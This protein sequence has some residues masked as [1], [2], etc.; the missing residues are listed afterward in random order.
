MF[1]WPPSRFLIPVL[2]TNAI[3]TVVHLLL[4]W[5]WPPSPLTSRDREGEVGRRKAASFPFTGSQPPPPCVTSQAFWVTTSWSSSVGENTSRQQHI[6]IPSY[7]PSIGHLLDN[8][9]SPFSQEY[10]LALTLQLT[11]RE[12]CDRQRASKRAQWMESNN[13]WTSSAGTQCLGQWHSDS[14]NIALHQQYNSTA[15]YT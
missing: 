7:K 5:P 9:H 1:V 10:P 12:A 4:C 11:L 2:H 14:G 3:V 15:T 6:Q 8:C 13:Y